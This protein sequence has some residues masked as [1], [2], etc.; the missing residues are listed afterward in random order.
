[1][2]ETLRERTQT[3]LPPIHRAAS[4]P[5]R[6]VRD[7]VRAGRWVRVRRG[8]YVD[9]SWLAGPEGG[10]EA[11]SGP[12]RQ[13]VT[14][15]RSRAVREHSGRPPTTPTYRRRLAVA[16]VAAV[17]AT[18]ARAEEPVFTHVSAALLWGLPLW[19][20]PSSVHVLGQHSRGRDASHL[21]TSHVIS[22]APEHVVRLR[23]LLVTS[24]DRTMLDVARTEPVADA[25]VVADAALRRGADRSGVLELASRCSGHR[26]IARARE[27]LSLA[28][29][30]AESPW[31]SFTRL[32]VLA[33]GLPAPRL[34]VDVSTRQGNYRADMGW[35][36]W[37]QLIEFDGKVKYRELANG[38]PDSV[39]L[40]EKRRQ[41]AMTEVGWR[42]LRLT[43]DDFHDIDHLHHRLRA[44]VPP[45]EA[46]SLTPR[47]QLLLQ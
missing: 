19:R 26:G 45:R 3:D 39:L 37:R 25:L 8:C 36:A 40:A 28:D 21:T 43:S 35:E 14:G 41:D 31:E 13:S 11:L 5:D 32:H 1:M 34:Q 10:G 18:S 47:P 22:L 15:Y 17:A 24:V 23:G 20:L 16:Q 7:M 42:I 38:D 6:V 33:A 29:A 2:T 12:E 4:H 44:L 30:G 46:T 27:T 9:A